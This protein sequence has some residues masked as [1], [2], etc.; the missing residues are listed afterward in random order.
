MKCQKRKARSTDKLHAKPTSRSVVWKV[1]T[2][3][4]PVITVVVGWL[5]FRRDTHESEK[6]YLKWIV[7]GK[8]EIK[9]IQIEGEEPITATGIGPGIIHLKNLLRGN[10]MEWI[11]SKT[12][13]VLKTSKLA[14]GSE[15]TNN[16]WRSSKM[17]TTRAKDG[18][19]ALN[20]RITAVTKLPTELVHNATI[21]YQR[22]VPSDHY[23]PHYD[24]KKLSQLGIPNSKMSY[25]YVGRFL[26]VVIYLTN[27]NGSHTIF[28][29][30]NMSEEDAWSYASLT[31]PSETIAKSSKITNYWTDY[32]NKLIKNKPTQGIAVQPVAGDAVLFYNHFSSD[33][34]LGE[35]NPHSYHAGCTVP[36]G[37]EKYMM[38]YW[39][40]IQP[41][42]FADLPLNERLRDHEEVFE[43]LPQEWDVL[44]QLTG[45]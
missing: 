21:Q 20:K 30:S 18:L 32:C 4:I 29:F 3:I 34:L 36:P 35:L 24:S 27:S 31:S 5:C 19:Q 23:F 26:T 28:P 1:L 38:N 43:P 37:N 7:V 8:N 17:I 42:M 2:A 11:I 39:F 10:E 25:P 22:Y 16:G 6:G 41:H 15:Q 13:N 9:K 14:G 33:G 12:K 44:H 40:N 45:S